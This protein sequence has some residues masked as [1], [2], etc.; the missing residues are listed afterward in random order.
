MVSPA[1]LS[2]VNIITILIF[3]FIF[4]VLFSAVIGGIFWWLQWRKKILIIEDTIGVPQITRKDRA[5]AIRFKDTGLV[6]FYLRKLK[7]YIAYPDKSIGKNLYLFYL[8]DGQ[9]LVNLGFE[10]ISEKMGKLKLSFP[11]T[12]MSIARDGL[13]KLFKDKFNRVTF[14][15]KYGGIISYTLLIMITGVVIW[16]ILDKFLDYI[17]ALGGVADQ[18]GM[19]VEKVEQLLVTA[20]NV[21]ATGGLRPA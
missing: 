18:L 8:K 16:L 15:D 10:D 12:E 9:R 20:D 14:W 11:S 21:Q 1:I 17:T 2:L 4:L 5:K 3:F 7:K 13:V 6:I 19:V